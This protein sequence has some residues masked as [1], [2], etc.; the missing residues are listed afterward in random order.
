MRRV[1]WLILLL[2]VSVLVGAPC[3]ARAQGL[4]E[5][6]TVR[7]AGTVANLFEALDP[8]SLMVG[9]RLQ[10]PADW[11]V[12][13]V[14]LLRYGT[15]P[16]PVQHRTEEEGTVL[17]T[18]E[19]PIRGPHEL[20]LR[21]RTS[22]RP[23][24]YRWQITPLAEPETS[25]DPDSLEQRHFRALDR[26]SRRVQLE[27]PR[28]PE[29][30]NRALDLSGSRRPLN[31]RL[32]AS[33]SLGREAS[34]TVEFWMRTAG[35]D[36]VLLSTWTGEE[37]V[38]YSAEFVVDRS[39]RLRFYSGR[40]GNHE[41]LRTM[42][43]VA[44]DRWHHAAVVYDEVESRLHLVLDGSV[45]D[46]SRSR[47]LPSAPPEGSVAIGG[48]LWRSGDDAPR[49]RYTGLLDELRIW[50]EARSGAT[51]RQMKGRPFPAS[52]SGTSP[53][54]FRLSFNED[55]EVERVEWPEGGRRVPT[56]LSFRSPLRD[57]RA[58]TKG[59]S[60]TLRWRAEAAETGTFVVERSPDGASFTPVA[61][62]NPSRA[63]PSSRAQE[64]VYTDEEVP[65][66]LVYYR[67]RQVQ[68]D[69]GIERLTGT[70]KVGL[71]TERRD[72]RPVEL[73]GNFPNPFE[74]S[75]RVAYRVKETST[76]TLTVWDLSGKQV[77]TL[78]DGVHAAGYYEKSLDAGDLPS[79]PY[80]VRL[81][82]ER[83]VQ[84]HRMVLLK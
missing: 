13:D 46:S 65:E 64:I 42:A 82:T 49:K 70:L 68:P 5:E 24:T 17:L 39:G 23:G 31:V 21:V 9:A 71:G 81:E 84:S 74:R 35:L 73:V 28:R 14:H 18:T 2:C 10:L 75:T 43:P 4:G 33:L 76:L 41:A 59:R 51:L 27:R 6:A 45:V 62:L 7:T 16:V 78:A 20:V 44:D 37:T 1:C 54:P 12:Q 58:Q 61:R 83:G 50:P 30:P 69:E 53:G 55:P 60:V 56:V 34:F 67:I 48:R 32:P 38:P 25:E 29:G 15:V 79:G 47:V 3:D 40:S 8:S 52:E 19:R 26:F 57:L 22:D 77:A 80:F 63:G 36:D 11:S 72:E 66:N